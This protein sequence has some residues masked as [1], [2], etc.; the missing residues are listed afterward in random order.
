MSE[1]MSNSVQEKK[2]AVEN[3]AGSNETNKPS[4][5]GAADKDATSSKESSEGSGGL[6]NKEMKELKK[7]EK[8]AKRAAKKA[9]A[10]GISIEKQQQN[11]E[12]KKEKKQKQK[13]AELKKEQEKEQKIKERKYGAAGGAG[14]ASKST[15]F[16]HLETAAERKAS[17]LAV[18]AVISSTKQTKIT[19][20]GLSLQSSIFNSSPELV[21]QPQPDSVGVPGT[22]SIIP[23]TILKE[24]SGSSELTQQIKDLIINKDML[25]K[26]TLKLTDDFAKYNIVGSTPRCLAMLEVFKQIISDYQ[27]PPGTILSRNLTQYLS[28]Q[29][30]FIT[31]AR[32]LSVTMGNTIRWLKQQISMLDVDVKEKDA[33]QLLLE[34]IDMFTQEKIKLADRVIVE[35]ASQHIQ[36]NST[37]VTYGCSEV[38][39]ELFVHNK[40]NLKKDF[41]VI[42]VDSRPLHEGKKCA[43]YLKDQGLD[44]MYCMITSLAYVFQTID[45]DY[46]IMGAHSI[47]SNGFMYSRVGSAMLAMTAKL[48]NIPV[49][50]CCETLKFTNRVQLDSLTFN[51]LADPNDLL[52]VETEYKDKDEFKNVLL[53][54]FIKD[55]KQFLQS[56]AAI[57]ESGS[58]KNHGQKANIKNKHNAKD[59][60]EK[61]VSTKQKNASSILEKWETNP[62][63][64]I[65]NT[66]YDLTPPEYISKIITESGALPPSSV[67]VIIREYNK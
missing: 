31:K 7:Q 41:K 66:M 61:S 56:K 9:A 53:E 44:V 30:D 47:L 40:V 6:S 26:A 28:H 22:C 25:H 19:S 18:N 11:A 38:L 10:S 4:P 48:K 36:N 24:V 23:D 49:I 2:E 27:T 46:V 32:P 43:D 52:G 21:G 13:E 57:A 35:S 54:Q 1:T 60:S 14:L 34:S 15:L 58:H 42:I 51:E 39:K 62:N 5:S 33:K 8:A 64:N 45:I 12:L 65:F 55:K 67:P 29:I 16:G 3:S 37:I 63:F 59:K 20:Q 17:L 50:I